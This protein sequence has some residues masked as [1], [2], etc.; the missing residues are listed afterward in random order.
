[1]KTSGTVRSWSFKTPTRYSAHK[2]RGGECLHQHKVTALDST[3]LTIV[4]SP[5]P[6][7]SFSD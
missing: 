1:M 4:V 7:L 2:L 3:G 5:Q 6:R